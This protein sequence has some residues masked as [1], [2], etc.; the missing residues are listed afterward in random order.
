VPRLSHLTAGALLLVAA[1]LTAAPA[2]IPR[3]S[4]APAC[5]YSGQSPS[6]LTPAQAEQSVTCLINKARRGNGT[7][8][9]SRDPRLASAAGGHS[10][11]MD[12]SNFFSHDGD[13]S[14]IDRIRAS[15][16]LSGASTWM[17]GENIAWGAGRHGT[18][19]ATVGRWMGSPMHR[20]AMLSPRFRDVGV[21]VAI[22]SP[23][24]GGG[25]NAAI[26][27]ADFG[28]SR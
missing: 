26:Y 17:I 15:G 3:S 16:Y 23:L 19:K 14:P 8:P 9:L 2:A 5:P 4:G 24:G 25:G 6:N 28:L 7:R 18:P 22:G 10:A 11:A 21:G 27:T 12:S 20:S 13:G 1:A